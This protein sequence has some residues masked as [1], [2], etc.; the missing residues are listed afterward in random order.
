MPT[1]PAI[2]KN[3]KRLNRLAAL[4]LALAGLAERAAGS[5]SPVCLLVLWLIRPSEAVARDLVENLAPGAVCLPE[6]VGPQDAAA[7]ALRLAHGFR[8][9]A[10]ILVALAQHCLAALPAAFAHRRPARFLPSALM[11]PTCIAAVDPLDSS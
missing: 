10:A 5:S 4:L 7:E 3:G 8:V 11:P 6:P 2:A 9:L 1:H